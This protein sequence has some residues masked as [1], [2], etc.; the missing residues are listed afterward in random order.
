VCPRS[1]FTESV[2]Q[3]PVGK[4]VTR[5]LRA[6]AGH[7][8][9]EGARTEAQ[10]A[11]DFGL[12]WPVVHAAFLDHATTVLPE[13]PGPVVALGIDETR[14]GRARC[15]RSTPRPG[16]LSRSPTGGTPGLST[17]PGIRACWGRSKALQW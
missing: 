7:A 8:V 13:E 10:A 2:P 14:R 4:R 9:A 11:R 1:S 15:V 12:S 6:A 17:S 3:I 5:R 16:C